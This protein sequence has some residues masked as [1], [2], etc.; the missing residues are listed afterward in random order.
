MFTACSLL[1]RSSTPVAAPA[2]Y[3]VRR[4]NRVMTYSHGFS[5]SSLQITVRSKNLTPQ[6][7][8]FQLMAFSTDGIIEYHRGSLGTYCKKKPLTMWATL[9]GKKDTSSKR[10]AAAAA[11]TPP[12][13]GNAKKLN[14][15]KTPTRPTVPVVVA[16]PLETVLAVEAAPPAVEAAPAVV[17]AVPPVAASILSWI[18]NGWLRY[19]KT[20]RKPP[21]CGLSST[22]KGAQARI[23]FH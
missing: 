15:N 10:P 5:K 4:F 9:S 16:A 14:Q 3:T 6:N 11:M 12:R 21:H 18:S 23:Y 2:L 7:A 8:I 20:R 1:Y 19:S 17:G 13:A 22:K